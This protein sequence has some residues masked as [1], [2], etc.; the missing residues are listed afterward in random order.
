M[1]A[2]SNILATY[3]PEDVKL[4][5]T[6]LDGSWSHT[7]N[8]FADGTFLTVERVIPHATLYNGAD[9]SNV[10]VV[11]AV[12]NCDLT[13]SLHLASE[14]N[15]VFSQLLANDEFSR[16]GSDCFRVMVKDTIGRTVMSSPAA[17]IGTSPTAGFSTDVETRD[18]VIHAINLDIHFGGNGAVTP[19]TEAVL[20]ELG[21]DLDPNWVME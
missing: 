1:A 19:D 14:S 13:A 10:R 9:K 8:G 7:V 17:F 16:D 6:A 11:R 3:S 15:D 4:I 21:Y 12:K 5:L 2:V 20:Q 18:W